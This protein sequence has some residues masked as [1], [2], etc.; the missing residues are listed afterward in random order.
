MCPGCGFYQP[1][2]RFTLDH[3]L[4]GATRIVSFGEG[5]GKGGIQWQ[6]RALTSSER[7]LIRERLTTA[8]KELEG[9]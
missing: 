5:R 6:K 9:G 3:V 7:D 1:P 4:M 2:M 8:L